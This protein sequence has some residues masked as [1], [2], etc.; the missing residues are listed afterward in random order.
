[1]E[2]V[3]KLKANLKIQGKP[4]G[5]CQEA[6]QLGDDAALCNACGK[7]HHGRCWDGKAGCSTEGCAS[8]PLRRLDSPIGKASTAAGS[9]FPQG[10]VVPLSQGL[11]T[12]YMACPG[13]RV[14]ILVGSPIC[15]A[16]KAI[17]SP[18]GIYHGPKTNAPGAV[19][20]LVFGL[21]GLVLC[22]I[23]LGPFAISK[24]NSAKLAMKSDPRLGGEGLATA[25]MVLGIVDLVVF[26]VY[27]M[28]RMKAL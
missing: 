21:I 9:P 2:D 10:P 24:A 26:A 4:C 13:C 25:G 17:T 12:G 28:L 20:S 23:I 16:C 27:V 5:W 7:E 11:G 15:P 14:E 3:R 6:L 19:Q 1:M 22:G 18:D 8:A